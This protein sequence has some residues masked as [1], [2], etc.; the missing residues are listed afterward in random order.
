MKTKIYTKT[1]DRGETSLLGG[2]RV[3]KSDKRLSA[4]GTVDELNAT[5]GLA[6]SEVAA[7]YQLKP[8]A[9]VLEQNQNI[10][11]IV[12]SHLACSDEAMRAHLPKLKKSFVEALEVA[13]DEL[14]KDLPELKEFILPGGAR[15]ASTLHLARTVCRRAEREIMAYL[16]LSSKDSD[17]PSRLPEE[18]IG[19]IVG[20]MNRL[21]DY[22]F[23]AARKANYGLNTPEVKWQKQV[24]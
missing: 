10:L 23:V 2:E 15:A 17:G 20:Y 18:L 7:V 16:D 8:I 13:I 6:L 12:G 14:E 1:G 24:D 9:E 3:L 21:G 22:L 5:L 11:F 19:L 4:Y